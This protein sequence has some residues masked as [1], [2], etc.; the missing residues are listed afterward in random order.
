M[1]EVT[2]PEYCECGAR[3][4]EHVAGHGESM[5]PGSKCKAF[6][7]VNME[8]AKKR[9][10]IFCNRDY[11]CSHPSESKDGVCNICRKKIEDDYPGDLTNFLFGYRDGLIPKLKAKKLAME[12]HEAGMDIPTLWGLY[13]AVK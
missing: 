7:W 2:I 10:C 9:T 13:K 8:I 12:I 4:E 1:S 11:S 5:I 3:R 6:H